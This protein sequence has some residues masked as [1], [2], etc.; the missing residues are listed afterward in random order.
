VRLA[1][2]RPYTDSTA[3]G[4]VEILRGL[5]GGETV[6]L[7]AGGLSEGAPVQVADATP[8]PGKR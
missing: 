8:P 5:S 1:L 3:V 2:R 6:V 4:V 7:D